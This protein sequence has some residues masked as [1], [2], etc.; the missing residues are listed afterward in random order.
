[1]VYKYAGKKSASVHESGSSLKRG[2]GEEGHPGGHASASCSGLCLVH[3]KRQGEAFNSLTPDE[4]E[5]A[6]SW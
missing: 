1:M 6:G 2:A 4:E 5:L 3:G